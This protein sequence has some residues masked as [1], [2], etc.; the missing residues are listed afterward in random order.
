MR[1]ILFSF[2]LSENEISLLGLIEKRKKRLVGSFC[3]F[4]SAAEKEVAENL[5]LFGRLRVNFCGDT[6]MFSRIFLTAIFLIKILL[7][8]GEREKTQRHEKIVC[9]FFLP[10]TTKH[11]NLQHLGK[12]CLDIATFLCQSARFTAW[13]YCQLFDKANDRSFPIKKVTH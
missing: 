10:R 4:L 3:C 7:L 2:P 5:P 8:L 1:G 12:W 11:S 6:P 13:F 9:Q